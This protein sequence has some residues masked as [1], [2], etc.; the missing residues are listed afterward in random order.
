MTH[1]CLNFVDLL[2]FISILGLGEPTITDDMVIFP[3]T[4][5]NQIHYWIKTDEDENTPW[6][7]SHTEY[8]IDF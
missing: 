6:C 5:D 1:Q 4:S 7:Y 3:P 2:F 8:S